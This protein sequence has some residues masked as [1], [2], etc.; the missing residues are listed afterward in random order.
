[1][2]P[3]SSNGKK[4]VFVK[5]VMKSGKTTMLQSTHFDVTSAGLSALV[6]K[7]SKDTKGK[8]YIVSRIGIKTKVNYLIDEDTNIFNLINYYLS[9]I[10]DKLDYIF[11]DE[12]QFLEVHHIEELH[13]LVYETGINVFCYGLL[14]DFQEG[15]F[16]ASKR[17]ITIGAELVNLYIPCDCGRNTATH[18]MRLVDGEPLFEGEQVEIDGSKNNISYIAKCYCCYS[19]ARAKVKGLTRVKYDPNQFVLD[20][21]KA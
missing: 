12:V 6:I 1:M 8:D 14:T 20:E 11:V 10:N 7:S 21:F 3:Y 16:D 17:L 2:M 5:G 4:F 9:N 13:R 15:M 19:E 18:N